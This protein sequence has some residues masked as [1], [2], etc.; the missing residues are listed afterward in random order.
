MSSSEDGESSGVEDSNE[1][2]ASASPAGN[3]CGCSGVPAEV[4]RRILRK[5]PGAAGM[6]GDGEALDT[7]R[8]FIKRTRTMVPA[9]RPHLMGLG[10]HL[11]L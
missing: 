11:G 10:G 8:F 1:V 2:S 6:K 3:D 5:S 7:L 9:C 4:L